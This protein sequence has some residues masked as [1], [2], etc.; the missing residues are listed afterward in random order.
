M[1]GGQYITA[2]TGANCDAWPWQS[3][4]WSPA[5]T[6]P[7]IPS[8]AGG[9][10]AC[11]MDPTTGNVYLYNNA[12]RARWNRATNTWQSNAFSSQQVQEGA[13]AFDSTRNV[14]WGVGDR[15]VTSGVLKWDVTAE[16][17]SGGGSVTVQ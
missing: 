7:A 2:G 1:L 9:Q 13:W 3:A 15:I 12:Q 5:G 17:F 4:N 14:I 6:I 16:T 11:V 8:F 10:P